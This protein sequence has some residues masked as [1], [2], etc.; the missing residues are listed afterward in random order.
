MVIFRH[1]CSKNCQFSMNFHDNSRNR[2]RKSRKIVYSFV[3]AHCA[4]FMKVRSKLRGGFWSYCISFVGTE[5]K[6]LL[7]IRFRRFFE[8]FLVE[9]F[10]FPFFLWAGGFFFLEKKIRLK[11]FWNVCSKIFLNFE[12][13]KRKIFLQHNF[14]KFF[15]FPLYIFFSS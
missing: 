14:F 2:N 5:P 9:I 8:I 10:F 12:K 11:I 6:Y 15:L 13:K 7:S 4:S 1:F 3:S